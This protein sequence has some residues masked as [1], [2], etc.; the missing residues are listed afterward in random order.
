MD[1]PQPSVRTQD[2]AMSV[3][4][5]TSYQPLT[6]RVRVQVYRHLFTVCASPLFRAA[7][8]AC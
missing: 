1:L 5:D 6:S 4:L 8:R 7:A 3:P 2:K